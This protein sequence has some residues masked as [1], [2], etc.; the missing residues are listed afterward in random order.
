ME[1]RESLVPDVVDLEH[2]LPPF[3]GREAE[4]GELARLWDAGERLITLWGGPGLGKTRLALRFAAALD[5]SPH[6]CRIGD[7]TDLASACA[8][9]VSRLGG[10]GDDPRAVAR[11][12]AAADVPIVVLDACETLAAELAP[13]VAKWHAQVPDARLVLTSRAVLGVASEYVVELGPL[14]LPA[15]D[16]S[17]SA[18]L[19]LFDERARRA[20][21]KQPFDARERRKAAEIVTRLQGIPLAIE[22]TAPL[23]RTLS[24][25]DVLVRLHRA[26][27]P[28]DAMRAAVERSLDLLD[29]SERA[30]L[31]ALSIFRGGFTLE[32]AEHVLGEAPR[33]ALGIVA[34]LRDKS[35]L[36]AQEIAGSLRLDLYDCVSEAVVAPFGREEKG[37]YVDYYARFAAQAGAPFEHLDTL[38]RERHNL[39]R[40]VAFAIELG[41]PRTGAL[42]RALEPVASAYGPLEP[43][44]ALCRAAHGAAI[45][46]ERARLARTLGNALRRAGR[47][48]ESEIELQRSADELDALG[49][50]DEAAYARMLLSTLLPY[51]QGEL[52]KAARLSAACR[53]AS[54][55]IVD[56][57]QR[58]A[59]AMA[60][61]LTE[62]DLGRHEAARAQLAGM[63]EDEGTLA[64]SF[65]TSTFGVLAIER[66]DYDEA[67]ARLRPILDARREPHIVASALVY[68]AIIEHAR[69]DHERA[70]TMEERALALYRCV[71]DRWHEG[72]TLG[73]MGIGNLA[74][75]HAGYARAELDE[76]VECLVESGERR[77]ARIFHAFAALSRAMTSEAPVE[78]IGHAPTDPCLALTVELLETT[79]DAIS[80][81][82]RGFEDAR[83]RA[84]AP[85]ALDGSNASPAQRWFFVRTAA[86]IATQCAAAIEARSEA[87][88]FLARH[89]RTRRVLV[90]EPSAEWFELKPAPRRSCAQRHVLRRLL[91]ALVAARID[92]PGR[93]LSTMELFERGWPGEKAIPG[94][95]SN[96]VYVSI[97][98][99]RRLGLKDILVAR[100]GGYLLDP[101]IA[102]ERPGAQAA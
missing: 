78:W 92:S 93:A 82:V 11:T 3:V 87:P 42:V 37:R 41:D 13:C 38:V 19:D 22:L 76:A 24:L 69:G 52:E 47:L 99:L 46:I 60:I 75:G 71:G 25:D 64:W 68:L 89:E 59:F 44:V 48:E 56:S 27:L 91:A 58:S 36:H 29:P 80:G 20:G 21:R 84:A 1:V 32:A 6:F 34:T 102:I 100:E 79:R 16:R 66:E 18:A 40:A 7:A 57:A 49:E 14:S 90:V 35:L 2:A 53:A 65:V 54:D 98:G 10:Q 43:F 67:E 17:H 101:E 62:I 23:L 26:D 9:I 50:P 30:A 8:L 61:A 95:A 85:L 72:W 81:A 51:Q 74:C 70:R 86:S 12:L 5:P 31:H 88:T 4:L 63:Q 77:L 97:A 39:P 73:H 83:R 28:G 33:P 94:S 55:R 96:R 15:D 45:G